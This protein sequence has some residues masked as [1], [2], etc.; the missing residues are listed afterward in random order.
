MVLGAMFVVGGVAAYF[1]LSGAHAP[2]PSLRIL[3]PTANA[4]I[5]G[6]KTL[7]TVELANAQ[8]GVTGTTGQSKG[9]HLHYYLD[10]VI[11]TAPGQSAVSATG[12]WASSTKTSHEWNI[13]G[14]GL[15]V[16]A[17]QLV[18]GDDRPL[19]QPVVAAVV[20]QVPKSPTVLPAPSSPSNA[21]PARSA[22]GC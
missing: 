17:A 15:H 7:V 8:V 13:G 21:S 9:Y 4:T 3:S 20:V 14:V 19:S 6:G 18:T 1:V 22:G 11:P 2:S 12:T 10:A 16:L 5:P